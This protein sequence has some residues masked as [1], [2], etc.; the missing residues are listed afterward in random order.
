MKTHSVLLLLLSLSPMVTTAGNVVDERLQTYQKEGA[1]NFNAA[2]GQ[3]MWT[4]QFSQADGSK[5]RSCSSC[6][7][8]DMRQAGKHV[9]TGK[10]IDAM[11]P[12]VNPQRL[13]D[14]E[15]IEKWFGRN[16]KWTLGRECTAQEKGDYLKYIQSQ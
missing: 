13:T 9:T 7:T 8:S 5:A 16:C 11:S 14:A 3:A 1:S 10:T 12:A 2:A 4:K 6:H 15:K